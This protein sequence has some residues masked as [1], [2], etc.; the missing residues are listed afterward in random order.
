MNR[1]YQKIDTLFK[2]DEKNIIIPSEFTYPEL[3]RSSVG[4]Y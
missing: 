1:D 4:V 2:R 3:E